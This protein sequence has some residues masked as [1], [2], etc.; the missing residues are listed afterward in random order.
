MNNKIKPLVLAISLAVS[1]FSLAQDFIQQDAT[2]A[3]EAVAETTQQPFEQIEVADEMMSA[4]EQVTDYMMQRGWGEGWDSKKKRLFVV[5]SESFNTEDPSYDDSFIT[6]RSTYAMLATMGAKAKMV[7]F[8]RT[9]MSA[10]DQLNAPGTDVYAELNKQY[11]KLEKKLASQQKKLMK[12]LED[13]N[14][15]EADKLK[16][17]TWSDRSDAFID[18]VIKKL[19][20]SYSAGNIQDDKIAKYEKAKSRYESAQ[21]EMDVLAEK[22]KA[23]RGSV[24]LEST[25]TVETLAKAPILGASILVQAESW[26]ADEEEYQVAT[27]MVWS[28]KLESAAKAIITGEDVSVKPKQAMTV[29]NWL[30]TQELSTLV[31]PRQYVDQDGN[32]WFIGVFAMPYEGSSSLKRKNKGIAE[33][34]AKKEAAMALY[35]DIEVQKQAAIALQTRSGDLQSNDHTETATSLAEQTRQSIENRP[36]NGLSKLL[37]KTVTHPISQ[38]KIHVVAYGIS[39]DSATQALEIER[40]SLGAAASSNRAIQQNTANKKELDK[41]LDR[42]KQPVTSTSASLKETSAVPNTKVTQN[43]RQEKTGNTSLLNAPTIDE[44]DF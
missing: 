6:K 4:E 11:L 12:L 32:R 2:P 30:K 26:N 19:D 24:A 35:A 41:A 38:Q 22:A 33:A 36:V 14:A 39:A 1:P 43:T 17:V 42:S 5:H 28:P 23:I 8:M 16:G 40:S 9:Q 37:T 15:K 3:L 25:S 29:Q 31:G 21:S 13:V 18:A 20:E 27:L 34:F 7:E 44:D 10:T